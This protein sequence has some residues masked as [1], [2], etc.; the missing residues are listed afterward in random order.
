MLGAG[1]LVAAAGIA[2]G[3]GGMGDG[4]VGSTGLKARSVAPGSEPRPA[5]PLAETT[6]F[7]VPS[8]DPR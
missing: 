6:R 1:V 2:V 8:A 5:S 4:G 7:F 3:M